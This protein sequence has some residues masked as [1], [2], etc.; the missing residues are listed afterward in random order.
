MNYTQRLRIQRSQMH[1]SIRAPRGPWSWGKTWSHSRTAESIAT[2][3]GQPSPYD[4]RSTNRCRRNMRPCR[5]T[6]AACDKWLSSDLKLRTMSGLRHL[7]S[8]TSTLTSAGGVEAPASLYQPQYPRMSPLIQDLAGC[9]WD[10]NLAE[11]IQYLCL[12]LICLDFG[13]TCV[14][15]AFFLTLVV[16]KWSWLHYVEEK[17]IAFCHIV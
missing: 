9:N 16:D 10:T 2:I 17:D 7:H 1:P 11:C 5:M 12:H 14:N 13:K 4:A 3:K 15:E 8:L 6:V